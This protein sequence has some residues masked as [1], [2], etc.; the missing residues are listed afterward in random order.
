M[1]GGGVV[2][3]GGAGAYYGYVH[4]ADSDLDALVVPPEPSKTETLPEPAPPSDAATTGRPSPASQVLYPGALI[5]ARQWAD[6]RGAIDADVPA[7]Q[8]FT[9]VSDI[10]RQSIASS[11]RRAE[12]ILIP[13]LKVD[14]AIEEL[15]VLDVGDSR[16]YE[17]PPFAVGHIPDS[18]D[19]GS[20][21]NG[22]YFGHL[23]TPL[24]SGG[25]VFARLPSVP[26]LL[27]DGEDVHII[28]QSSGRDYL[29]LVTETDL[30]HEDDMHLYQASNARVTLVTC[31]P[32]LAYDHRL[33]VTAKL[34]GFRNS[35]DA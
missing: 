27:R 9:P 31:F 29:Y 19:A 25:N 6:P 1:L 15:A 33:L 3:L 35:A 18:P 13:A 10:G 4:L 28:L 11:A 32:R 22:W 12:R 23:E 8:G 26:T 17:T 16:A 14:A 20:S 30:V 7:L 21:G 34:V 2:L 5:P 24:Q